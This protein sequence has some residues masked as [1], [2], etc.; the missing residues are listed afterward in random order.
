MYFF[1]YFLFLDT[2][3]TRYFWRSYGWIIF[4]WIYI[5]IFTLEIYGKLAD[6]EIL[7]LFSEIQIFHFVHFIPCNFRNFVYNCI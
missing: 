3:L 6:L 1:Y 2:F 7:F 5:A 4:V